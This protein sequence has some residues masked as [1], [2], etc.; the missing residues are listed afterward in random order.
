MK[1][2]YL[3]ERIHEDEYEETKSK[4]LFFN[5]INDIVGSFSKVRGLSNAIDNGK[6]SK[7]K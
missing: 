2:K 5:K 1:R 4:W 3:E 6:K 7:T